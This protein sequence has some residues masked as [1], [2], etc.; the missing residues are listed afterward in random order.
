MENNYFTEN[1]KIYMAIIALLIA[2]LFIFGHLYVGGIVLVL[3]SVLVFYNIKIFKGKKDEWE[4]FMEDFVSKMNISTRSVLVNI[5]FPLTIINGEGNILW[6]NENFYNIFEKGEILGRNINEVIN[7]VNI[8][9]ILNK[10]EKLFTYVKIRDKYYNIF[11]NIKDDKDVSI[12]KNKI[13]LLYF[14]DVTEEVKAKK[15]KEN[16]KGAVILVEVDNL[17]DV[18]KTTEEDKALLL[19]AEIER[20]IKNYGQNMEATIKKYSFNKY[21]MV[22]HKK[23]INKEMEKNFEILDEI[24]E[25]NFGNKLAVTLSVGIGCGGE[26][27]LE[28]HHFAISAKELALSRGGDQVVVKNKDKLEF[29]GG[30]TKEV[31][32][33]TKVRA[34]V[35]AHALVD[36][37]KESSNVFIMG[38]INPDID[39]LGAAMGINSVAKALGKESYVIL[40]SINNG[41]ENAIG[42]IKKENLFN[43]TFVTKETCMDNYDKNSLLILVDVNSKSH[44]H[45]LEIVQKIDRIVIIDHH[46]KST[47]AVGE[48]LLNYIEPYA[49]STCELVTEMLQYMIES[50]KDNINSIEAEMMLAGIYVDTKNFYF[51]AGVRTFEAAAYLRQLGADITNVKKMFAS[52][53]ESYLKRAKI[54]SLAKIENNI[55]ITVC[56]PEIQDNVLAAQVADELLN[57][58]GVQASFVLV[59]IKD[60]VFISGRSFG[61]INVQLILETLGGGG[62][63]TIAGTKLNNVSID[64]AKEKLKHAIDKYLREGEE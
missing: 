38:H 29:Y 20:T 42:K 44:V 4:K 8:D 64:E 11:T 30:K 14:Y 62:H 57:I 33:R 46:R 25:I 37:I 1:N 54:M 55:S 24:R 43:P 39:A 10:D 53:L 35:V 18:L 3:Y 26:T 9:L 41:I 22:V 52:D 47:D 16:I 56:P 45:D 21:I 23:N 32:K 49:S 31:E 5:P 63:L 36:I 34:R 17:D 2:I 7:E 15:E 19:S 60:E 51:K 28:N 50:P 12:N 27:P 40:D 58:T 13:V 61:D 59:K 6:Y 48:T